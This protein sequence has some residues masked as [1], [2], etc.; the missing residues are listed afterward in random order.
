MTYSEASAGV[1]VSITPPPA[2]PPP[3]CKPESQFAGPF[4]WA[5]RTTT[6]WQKK[7]KAPR[8]THKFWISYSSNLNP[9]ALSREV[10]CAA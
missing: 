5:Y 4:Q 1:T 10:T 7:G 9:L 8:R 2:I 6:V 3:V